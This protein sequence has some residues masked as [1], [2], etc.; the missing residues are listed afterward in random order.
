MEQE[1]IYVLKNGEEKILLA[2]EM[3]NDIRYLLL[4]DSEGNDFQIAYEENN[5]LNFLN[6]D[7]DNFTTILGILYKK[8]NSENI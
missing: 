3:F 2:R 7:D 5:C 6:K 8:L 4:S 1:R